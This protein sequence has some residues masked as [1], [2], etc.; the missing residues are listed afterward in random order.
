MVTFTPRRKE[1]KKTRNKN[2]ET[3]PIFESSYLGDTWHDLV[4]IWNV[5]YCWWRASPQQ[6]LFGFVQAER[7]YIYTK[8]ALL[9]FLLI[10]LQV[11]RAGFLGRTTH[12]HVS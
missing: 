5:G 11:W 6:K 1:E 7:S 4:E 9:F 10:Y 8:I 3:K 2:K 12:D